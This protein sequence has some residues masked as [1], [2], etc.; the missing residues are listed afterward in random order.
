MRG[1][2][3]EIFGNPVTVNVLEYFLEHINDDSITLDNLEQ[4]FKIRGDI[5]QPIIRNLIRHKFIVKDA[6]GNYAYNL[7]SSSMAIDFFRFYTNEQWDFI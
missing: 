6:N 1:K 4:R 3:L 5:L 7:F 2:L